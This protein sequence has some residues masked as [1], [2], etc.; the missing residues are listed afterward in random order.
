MSKRQMVLRRGRHAGWWIEGRRAGGRLF[1]MTW[2]PTKGMASWVA[3]WFGG[4]AEVA[5][6]GSP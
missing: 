2:W 1:M 3:H 6:A 5:G 4:P